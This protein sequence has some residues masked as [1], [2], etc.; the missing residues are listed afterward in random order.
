MSKQNFILA[1]AKQYV[2]QL[3]SAEVKL[4]QATLDNG[5]V[6]EAES[7]EAGEPVFIVGEDGE[8]AETVK[9]AEPAETDEAPASE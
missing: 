9:K 7:W 6:I 1:K 4:M 2:K 5:T 8:T 3:L